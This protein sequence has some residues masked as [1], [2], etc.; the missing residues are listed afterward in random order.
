MILLL[1]KNLLIEITLFR[2][3]KLRQILK[4]LRESTLSVS[5]GG[6]EGVAN[7]LKQKS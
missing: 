4:L 3:K 2:V 6:P 1:I 7:F 5:E